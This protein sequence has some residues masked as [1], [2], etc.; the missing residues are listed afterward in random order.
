[1]KV[2]NPVLLGHK[3]FDRSYLLLFK[4]SFNYGCLVDYDCVVS[5]V[6]MV[7]VDTSYMVF[8]VE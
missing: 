5:F 3:V 1:M 6:D 7:F 2:V 8:V 4:L